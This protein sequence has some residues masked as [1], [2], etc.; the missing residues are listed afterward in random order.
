MPLSPIAIFS[1]NRPDHLQQTL[2]ALSQNDLAHES[3]LYI[4]CDGPKPYDVSGTYQAIPH[5]SKSVKKYFKGTQEEYDAYCQ[6]IKE[7]ILVAQSVTWAKEL[8]VVTHDQ[9]LGLAD[10]IIGGVT[11]VVNQY[12]RIIMLEDDIITSPGFLRFMND[13][14]ECYKDDDQVMHICGY[15]FPV[16][17]ERW[18]PETFFHP[19]PYPGG[20]WATWARAWKY[21]DNNIQ[22]LYEYWS[23]DW[24]R[25]NV[26]GPDLQVQLTTNY[27]GIL[28]SWFIRWF[29]SMHK[30]DGLTLYPH[31]SLTTNIGFDGTG[32]N[33][34]DV[35]NNKFWV[36]ELAKEVKVEKQLIKP[37]RLAVYDMYVFWSGHWWSRRHR[38][39][40]KKRI[41]NLIHQ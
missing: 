14:L 36:T 10:S 13:A 24:K 20:G 6:S 37:N 34:A 39:A 25:F 27:T 3:V 9:N 7:N 8:H 32:V 11:E 38:E 12:G 5:A 30:R 29:A 35:K 17:H 31:H 23:K 40:L 1:Y 41:L 18:L 15:M 19:V 16:K 33:C 21:Y 26:W 4:F 22:S 28:K 2:D